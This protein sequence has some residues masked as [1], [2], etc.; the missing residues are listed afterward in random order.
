MTKLT[1]HEKELA[2]V[3]LKGCKKSELHI[4]LNCT[5][6]AV[7]RL[8]QGIYEKF[9]VRNIHSLYNKLLILRKK[10]NAKDVAKKQWELLYP[11]DSHALNAFEVQIAWDH[12]LKA[13]EV[14]YELFEQINNIASDTGKIELT[15]SQMMIKKQNRLKAIRESIKK[16]GEE[17]WRAIAPVEHIELYEESK[18]EKFRK[19]KK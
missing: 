18:R 16:M 10:N 3:L 13:F 14:A 1:F 19:A 17:N 5:E 12:W 4:A 7:K 15:Y 9:N 2:D 6:D 8:L 11:N